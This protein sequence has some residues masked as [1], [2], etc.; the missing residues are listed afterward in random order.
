MKRFDFEVEYGVLGP[1]KEMPNGKYVLYDDVK[2]LVEA[3]R[4][5]DEP[6]TRQGKYYHWTPV[7]IAREALKRLEGK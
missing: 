3:L 7:D 4:M 1:F 5:I 6:K 2:H